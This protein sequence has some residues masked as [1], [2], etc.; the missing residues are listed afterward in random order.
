MARR[1]H[2]NKSCFRPSKVRSKSWLM[3]EKNPN[4]PGDF[5][6]SSLHP[7]DCW[8]ISEPR[9]QDSGVNCLHEGSQLTLVDFLY[10]TS[11]HHPPS[12]GLH[13]HCL[14]NN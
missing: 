9:K 1:P 3:K 2:S 4:A 12:S 8:C 13:G 5:R 7:H 10:V 11:T 14:L 6:G